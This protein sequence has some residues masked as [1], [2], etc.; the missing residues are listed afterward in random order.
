MV[1]QGVRQRC[2]RPARL[3]RERLRREN[4]SR[5]LFGANPEN[6]WRSLLWYGVHR[7]QSVGGGID[8][9]RALRPRH[10]RLALRPHP[11]LKPQTPTPRN[12]QRPRQACQEEPTQPRSNSKTSNH[13]RII[14]ESTGEVQRRHEPVR[15]VRSGALRHSDRALWLR[16]DVDSVRRSRR[17]PLVARVAKQ[18]RRIGP[19]CGQS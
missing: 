7:G 18:P 13:A 2:T 6:A 19:V 12:W 1:S 14:A 4:N 3:R 16:D 17:L 5:S 11:L 8:G 10:P 15:S 9:L